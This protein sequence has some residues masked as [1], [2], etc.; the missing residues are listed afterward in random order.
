MKQ[1]FAFLEDVPNSLANKKYPTHYL[2]GMIQ[3]KRVMRRSNWRSFTVSNSYNKEK[4]NYDISFL[5]IKYSNDQIDKI[6][7]EEILTFS[8]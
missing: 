2:K 8:L 6:L 5:G 3:P 7:K 1:I 4:R